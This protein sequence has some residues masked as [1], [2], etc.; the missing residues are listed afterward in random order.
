MVAPPSSQ[1]APLPTD[2]PFKIISK[3]IGQGAYASVRK[4]IPNGR[5][6]PVVAI[7]F[8][9][10][11]HA[12]KHGRLTPK[13]V[14]MEILLHSHLGKH[15]NI[16][17]FLGNGED[18]AWTWIALEL[19]EGGDL[20]D[21][22]EA[23]EGVEEG[24]AHFY[25]TQLISAVGYM[26]TKG[27]AHRDLKPENVLL[28]LDG[29][30][31]LADFGL[32]AMFKKD[33]K[34]RL[35]NTICGSP[36]YIAPE[37]VNGRKSRRADMLDS[38]YMAN[39]C[40]IWSCGVVLFVLLVGNTP[41]D[42]PTFNSWEYK[43]YVDTNGRTTDEL[44]EKI[45]TGVLSLLRGMLKVDP[46]QRFTLDEIRTHP[47]FAQKNAFMNSKG[48]NAN[49]IGMAT[50]M[51]SSLRIDFSQ[52]PSQSQRGYSQPSQDPDVMEIDSTPHRSRANP[53]N[54][55]L[56]SSTQ[57]ETPITDTPFD[58]ERPPRLATHDGMSNS[59]P[60]ANQ[61]V[62][63]STG[64]S[65]H[66]TTFLSQLSPSTQGLLSQD[67]T[68]TQFSA[69]PSVPL[70]LTQ[71]AQHYSDVLPHYSFSRFLSPLSI[72][73]LTPLLFDALH[74]LGVPVP[75]NNQTSSEDQQVE[76]DRKGEASIRVKMADGRKQGLNGH[77]VVDKAWF[78]GA[79]MSEVRFVKASGDPV[80]WRRFFKNVCV[81]VGDAVL[82]A[83]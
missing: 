40:D 33:G 59:Q 81:C 2:L 8:I 78:D 48:Q 50:K 14:N 64:A 1:L 31:K 9:N 10:K 68:M 23:D 67:P 28:S 35:C 18:P 44:W 12:F 74:R 70:T 30:L 73:L 6:S 5:T 79:E 55:S 60:N 47:W 53:A 80:E 57:P 62:P 51:L 20:F 21:K 42:E 37:V 83:D 65:A 36:P 13:Q 19:A 75:L 63:S 39:I 11:E 56:L 77:I 17:H 24:I 3:T 43:E 26:H 66:P 58:W 32:A 38:G 34:T 76:W 45:P 22:V 52:P 69:R 82:K 61:K 16:I 27:I 4:A 7:K 29:D 49:P 41:W 71:Q 15:Q 25:F 46:T 54:I 72:S